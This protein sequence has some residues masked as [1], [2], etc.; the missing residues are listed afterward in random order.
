MFHVSLER[1]QYQCL[2]CLQDQ[3]D[4]NLPYIIASH[5]AGVKS[6]HFLSMP[7]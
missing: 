7:P 3:D 2:E 6:D 4:V 1:V 5:P